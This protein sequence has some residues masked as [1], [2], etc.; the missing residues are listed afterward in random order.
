MG[1]VLILEMALGDANANS[2]GMEHFAISVSS[3]HQQRQTF[4]NTGSKNSTKYAL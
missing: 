1:T 2:S 3:V 4:D